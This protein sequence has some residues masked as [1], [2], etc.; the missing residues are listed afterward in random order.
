LARKDWNELQQQAATKSSDQQERE[1]NLKIFP[2]SSRISA[3][4]YRL[5]CLSFVVLMSAAYAQLHAARHDPATAPTT[6]QLLQR[7]R[8]AIGAM[9]LQSLEV[10]GKVRRKVKY[11]E[12]SSPTKIEEKEKELTSKLKIEFVWPNKFRVREKGTQ[13]NGL[14]YEFL[15]IVNDREAWVYPQPIVPSTPENRRVVSVED[16]EQNLIR[17][18][19][20]ARANVSR[21]TVSWLLSS[22]PTWPLEFN[23][24]GRINTE[25]G[26][27]EV[28]SVRDSDGY[29]TLLLLDPNT[30]LPTMLNE[31][32][33]MPQ[34]ITVVPTG[35]GFD[36]RYNRAILMRAREERMARA[37]PPQPVSIQMRLS[38][39]RLVN[40]ISLPHRIT[41]YHNGIE[42]ETI[43]LDDFEI[44]QPINPKKFEE[45]R[46]Q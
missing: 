15:S 11:I 10:T 5:A 6:Q 25:A 21:F 42:V 7:A 32:I 2:K 41:T 3:V 43:E 26:V 40:G 37:K 46:P 36:R 8:A 27:N 38:D 13:L 1:S 23:Y 14:G 45:K 17:Q 19:Q 34:R 30:H 16:A 22:W 18:M 9:N 29:K 20:M 44:N 31:T 24:A 12:V 39:R 28:L 33:V 35:F 4:K